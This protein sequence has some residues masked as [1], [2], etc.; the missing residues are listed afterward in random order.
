[1]GDPKF[2]VT[3]HVPRLL[4]ALLELGAVR[5]ERREETVDGSGPVVAGAGSC[6]PPLPPW[7]QARVTGKGRES[8]ER[9]SG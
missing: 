8:G 1:M 5:A 6:G 3:D 7:T 2:S 4:E 9:H